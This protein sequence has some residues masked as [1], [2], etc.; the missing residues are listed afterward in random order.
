MATKP[1]EGSRIWR[2]M[3]ALFFGEEGE[4]SLRDQIEEAIDEADEA[5]PAKVGDLSPHER[6]M[7]RN[8]LHFADRT[9]GDICV[10][11]GD[12]IAVSRD[13]DFESLVAQFADAE[14]SRLPV[15]G[16]N[17]DEIVGMIHIKDLFA[18]KVGTKPQ[19][20][21]DLMR[22]PLFVPTTM[23]VIDILAS[24]RTQRV[25]MAVV[26]DEFGGT[27]GLVTIED[28]VEEIIGEIEDEHDETP[29]AAL[30]LLDEGV[31]EADARVEMEEVIEHVDPALAW[32][33]DEVDTLGGLAF[34]LAGRILEPGQSVEH[35]SGWRL[36]CIEAEPKRM[37]RLRIHA[38]EPAEP[39]VTE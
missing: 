6:T 35:P 25:H 4:Q 26:V 16:D 30:V 8:L 39:T 37:T 29:E 7:L 2:G 32:E 33:E 12:I 10:P 31:W 28:V 14:H 36:E 15:T 9:A 20:I 21:E 18:A 17:L 3:R 5:G 23:G 11:R 38:P 13:A 1:E 22:E 19:R 27:E 24:M 34:L